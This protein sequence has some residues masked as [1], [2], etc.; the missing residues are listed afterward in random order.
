ME[1]EIKR[2]QTLV[3]ELVAE[4][5]S[6]NEKLAQQEREHFSTREMHETHSAQV[7]AQIKALEDKINN[8][9]VELD[10]LQGQKRETEELL[11]SKTAEANQLSEEATNLRAEIMLLEMAV[12]EKQDQLTASL[13]K[14]EDSK[15]ESTSRIQS[16]TAQVAMLVQEVEALHGQESKLEEQILR[17][18]GEKEGLVFEMECSKQEASHLKQQLEQEVAHFNESLKVAEEEKNLLA[19]KVAAMDEEIKQGLGI[20]EHLKIDCSHLKEKMAEDKREQSSAQEAYEARISEATARVKLLEEQAIGLKLELENEKESHGLKLMAAT[21]EISGLKEHLDLAKQEVIELI[22]AKTTTEEEKGSLITKVS[23]MEEEIKR[24]QTLIDELVAESTSLKEKL[25][26]QEREHFSMRDMHET[27]SSKASAQIKVLEDK[28]NKFKLELDSLQGQKRETEERLE[29]KVA[30]ANQLS[31]EATNLRADI[32]L[33]EM[34]IKEKE[35]Q[36][37]SSLKKHEDRENESVSRI[38]SLTAQVASLVQEVEALRAETCELKEQIS[39][40]SGEKKGLEFELESVRQKASGLMQEI[41]LRKEEVANLIGMANKMKQLL[42]VVQKLTAESSQLKEKLAE[43]EQERLSFQEMHEAYVS[44]AAAQAKVFDEQAN[45]LKLELESLDFQRREAEELLENKAREGKHLVEEVANLHTHVSE[46]EGTVKQ[47]EDQIS[48]LLTKL[49][50]NEIASESRL[51]ALTTKVSNLTEEL[52]ALR[53]QKSELEEN[54]R[55]GSSEASAQIDDLLHRINELQEESKA[56]GEKNVEIQLE[57]ERKSLEIV[58]YLAQIECL[59]GKIISSGVDQ[60]RIIQERENLALKVNDLGLEVESVNN[61]KSGL[62]EQIKKSMDEA[63][64]SKLEIT[65]LQSRI[66]ELEKLVMEKEGESSAFQRK[67]E[68][69]EKEASSNIMTL[70]TEISK[71]REELEAMQIVRSQLETEMERGKQEYSNNQSKNIQL[72]NENAEIRSRVSE[73]EAAF[74]KLNQEYKQL[75]VQLQETEVNLQATEMTTKAMAEELSMGMEKQNQI[76][77]ELEKTVEDLK[78]ELE[79]AVKKSSADEVQLALSNQKLRVTEQ[80][81]DEKEQSHRAAKAKFQE[82]HKMLE[83]K[84]TSMSRDIADINEAYH[85][86]IKDISRKVNDSVAELGSII[87]KFEEKYEVFANSIVKVSEEI[88][89]T[90]KWVTVRASDNEQLTE[91]VNHLAQQLHSSREEG[92]LLKEK[93]EKLLTVANR[94]LG[95][96]NKALLTELSQQKKAVED[97]EAAARDKDELLSRLVEEKRE[98]IRQLCMW[99]DYH[100]VRYNELKGVLLKTNASRR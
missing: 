67:L 88:Q 68:E 93:M 75:E 42:D 7:S 100:M 58:E 34:T 95:E 13:K 28:I 27:Y 48:V 4:S 53:L 82:E 50:Y 94:G 60:E 61:Q 35:D 47:K 51:E 36:L 22:E 41:D 97:L 6:L 14:H 19:V 16:L 78:F 87:E 3:D 33:L 49:E 72:E 21:Q 12:E 70:S 55:R 63:V 44:G 29:S 69:G 18:S 74:I 23:V 54:I 81:L 11:E 46:L 99:I 52:D 80:L 5:T 71:L 77:V 66:L 24:G 84:V 90:K 79:M 8:F 86:M 20:I 10:S 85:G 56:I 9:K 62:E 31:E 83:E 38:Q 30:E 64:Q 25:A 91:E 89:M 2:R 73:Q 59:N 1:E 98:A 92:Q 65:G 76:V 45:G 39:Q 40:L 96:E 26:Q 17:Q 32:L 57:L 43:G 15:N 37:I